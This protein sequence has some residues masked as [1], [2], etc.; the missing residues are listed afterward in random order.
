MKALLAA[1]KESLDQTPEI[2][3]VLKQA[4]V[5]DAGGMGVVT[6]LEGAVLAAEGNFVRLDQ[7]AAIQTAKAVRVSTEE[8]EKI[9][10]LY[11]T[12]FLIH[13]TPER[14]T[15]QFMAAIRPKG[16]CM[17]VIEEDEIVKVHNRTTHP[18]IVIEQALKLGELTNLKIDNMK[19]QHEERIQ[20]AEAAEPD[21]KR[22]PFGFVAVSAGPGL[23]EV[24]QSIGVDAVVEGGQTMNPSTEDILNAVDKINAEHIFILPNNK[25]IILA[26]E[27]AAKLSEEKKLHVIPSRSVPEGISA[28]FCYEHDADPEEME[29][30][31]KD[32]IQKVDTATVTYA[33]R[34]TSIGDKQIKEGNILGMLNDEIEVVAEDV[35]EGTKELL[36]NAITEESEVVSIYYGA[37]TAEEDAKELSAFIEEEFPDCEVEVQDGG[38]P[39][40]YYIISIE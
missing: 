4:G 33:V 20:A 15:T 29:A 22:R 3:P 13:K 26:A 25:N 23:D 17:L 37:D 1:A 14:Q 11:C 5:V 40:Y 21:E 6:L 27:Q 18:G 10:F 32:P 24:F 8:A 30:A 16:D 19:Y 35:M 34:D 7:E 12:E 2:L 31:M 39:L 28:M 9:K 36:R 38:Q